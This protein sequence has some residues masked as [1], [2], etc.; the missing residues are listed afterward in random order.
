MTPLYCVDHARREKLV[1]ATRVGNGQSLC[2]DH[3]AAGNSQPIP[4][5]PADE[6]RQCAR[7]YP[8]THRAYFLIDLL[9]LCIRHAA[10]AVFEDDDMRAHDMAHAAYIGLR[11]AGVNDAY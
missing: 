11:S 5:S 4:A 2:A 8:T 9:A 6:V 7:C 3:A 10:D 1:V